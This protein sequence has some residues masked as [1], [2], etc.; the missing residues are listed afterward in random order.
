MSKIVNITKALSLYEIYHCSG[1]GALY[2]S[3]NITPSCSHCTVSKTEER[4]A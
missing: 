2:A 4:E 1:C 3:G